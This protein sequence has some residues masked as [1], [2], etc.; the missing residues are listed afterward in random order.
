MGMAFYQPFTVTLRDGLWHVEEL[1]DLLVSSKF[2]TC[3][4]ALCKHCKQYTLIMLIISQWLLLADS[5]RCELMTSRYFPRFTP[6]WWNMSG[7]EIPIFWCGRYSNILKKWFYCTGTHCYSRKDQVYIQYIHYGVC[8]V[9]TS[10]Y[11]VIVIVG[12]C[13]TVSFDGFVWT[14]GA[15]FYSMVNHHF[16]PLK[17]PLMILFHPV[18][19]WSRRS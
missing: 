4:E 3:R 16:S 7:R 14:L 19:S 9:P 5:W 12:T 6:G 15:Q 1:A 17:W 11:I 10:C 18:P 13:S 8:K 2:W